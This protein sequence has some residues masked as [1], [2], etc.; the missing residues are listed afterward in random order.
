MNS[1]WV[2]ERRTSRTAAGG[3]RCRRRAAGWLAATA[4]VALLAAGC[5]GDDDGKATAGTK[6]SDPDSERA[7]DYANCMRK[8]GVPNFP[9][10]VGGQLRLEAGPGTGIE[11]N[12]PAFK[13][14]QEACQSLAPSGL[15]SQSG[16]S[17][18]TQEQVLRFAR[19]MR[20]NGVP[21][22]PDP[23][24]S[25]GGGVTMQLPGVDTNSPEFQA[26]QQTCAK[27]LS[28]LEGAQ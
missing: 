17:S 12:S 11:P 18:D 10:P 23:D 15:Q 6:S 1:E 24:V 4:A 9:D 20:K 22:F 25:E 27:Y 14:A 28:G 3:R 13:S 26:A 21:K 7:L 2:G 16:G 8:H 19:C 5:G